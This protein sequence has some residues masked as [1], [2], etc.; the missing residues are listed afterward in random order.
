MLRD[1]STLFESYLDAFLSGNTE[2]VTDFWAF[3]A[4][5]SWATG[6][7]TFF[8]PAQFLAG[9]SQE[10]SLFQERGASKCKTDIL[11]VR[12]ISEMSALVRTRDLFAGKDGTILGSADYVFLI[13]NFETGWKIV[14]V[15]MD[16]EVAFLAATDKNP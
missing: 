12:R 9:M 5:V 1:I 11:E 4:Y 10:M 7:M 15:L 16:D 3:P 2:T 8:T 6:D 14:S 13:H